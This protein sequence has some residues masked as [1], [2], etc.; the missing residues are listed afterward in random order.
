MA[1]L[2]SLTAALI[3]VFG[4]VALTSLD[5]LAGEEKKES[6]TEAKSPA[7]KANYKLVAPLEVVMEVA[8]EMFYELPDKW[9][10]KKFKTVTKHALFLA[11]LANLM[12]YAD[13]EEA[14]TEPQK[15]EVKKFMTSL[16]EN[17]LKLSEASRKKDAGEVNRLHTEVEKACDACHDKYR[18]V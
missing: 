4:F 15:K 9:E 2:V 12:G 6:P 8:D 7:K 14:K 16:K 1:K 3:A 11:E 10:A 5:G 18:D 13:Y 17:F